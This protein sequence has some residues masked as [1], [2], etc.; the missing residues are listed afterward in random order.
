MDPITLRY[1]PASI[2]Y[3]RAPGAF[4]GKNRRETIEA[5]IIFGLLLAAVVYTAIYREPGSSSLS[6]QAT[7]TLIFAGVVFL[8]IVIGVPLKHRKK[9][10]DNP[11]LTMPVTW[12][13]DEEG[14]TIIND[15]T[16]IHQPWRT[17]RE[18]VESPDYLFLV[19]AQN[20]KNFL[21]L[22]KKTLDSDQQL[23][24]FRELLRQKIGL[25][26]AGQKR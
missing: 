7:L 19:D 6:P 14:L 2:D 15:M 3:V 5:I 10:N 20:E 9:F 16:R 17:F 12:E 4:R 8:V 1:M 22:T 13:A 24:A 11:Q 25:R 18:A 21:F 23:E 26:A